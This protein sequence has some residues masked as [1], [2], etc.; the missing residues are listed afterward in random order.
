MGVG[1]GPVDRG[2]SWRRRVLAV[3][4]LAIAGF[5]GLLGQLW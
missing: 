2:D 3:T 1:S 4:V 5:V